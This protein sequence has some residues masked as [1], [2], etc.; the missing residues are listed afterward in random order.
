MDALFGQEVKRCGPEFG[1]CWEIIDV[2]ASHLGQSGPQS[3]KEAQPPALGGPGGWFGRGQ[4][5]LLLAGLSRVPED[6]AVGGVPRDGLGRGAEGGEELAAV[7]DRSSSGAVLRLHDDSGLSLPL[8]PACESGAHRRQLADCLLPLAL[9]GHDAPPSP[10]YVI[11]ATDG[12]FARRRQ[13]DIAQIGT[14]V[15]LCCDNL[16]SHS[17]SVG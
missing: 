3:P 5:G 17:I 13:T 11:L 16:C 8:L 7:L 6:P 1:R 10:S 2:L 9:A 15:K 12:V 4:T 14:E